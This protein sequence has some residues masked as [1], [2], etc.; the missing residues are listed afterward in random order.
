MEIVTLVLIVLAVIVAVSLLSTLL[1]LLKVL[2]VGLLVG[3][4]ARW[5]LPGRQQVGLLRTALYGMCGAVLGSFVAHRLHI[6][7]GIFEL[8]F[9]VGA[10]AALFAVMGRRR[11]TR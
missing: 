9:E 1:A 7:S 4:V 2:V 6:Y 8:A 3:A 11:L 5:L 10:A